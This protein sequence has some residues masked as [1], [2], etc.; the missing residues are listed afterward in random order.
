MMFGFPVL[1]LLGI[2]GTMYMLFRRNYYQY[3]MLWVYLLLCTGFQG[4]FLMSKHAEVDY[5]YGL[6][7]GVI[8]V[9]KWGS[10]MYIFYV[11]EKR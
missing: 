3:Q 2:F 4:L 6:L 1:W 9:L 10:D 7:M 11:K 8:F 5:K